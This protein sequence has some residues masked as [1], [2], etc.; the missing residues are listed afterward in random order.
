MRA[1]GSRAKR[2]GTGH[3]QLLT[4][5]AWALLLL[6]LWVW[7]RDLTDEVAGRLP[8][9]GD[10]AAVGRPPGAPAHAHAP[11]AA[12][13][14]VRPTHLT[15]G[16]LGVGADVIARGLAT[17]GAVT[18]PPPTAPDVVGWY[19]GGPPPGEKGAAVLLGRVAA[20][21]DRAVFNGLS[22][23]RPGNLVEV[24]RSDGS[25]AQFTVED[26]KLYDRTHFDARRAYGAHEPGRSE[27]RLI[28]T[29]GTTDP[30]TGDSP[31][32]VVVSAHLTGFEPARPV[33]G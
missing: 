22:S 17:N 3:G 33:A 14:T 2:L 1:D 28:A 9:T 21:S 7:G 4:G 5:V 23:I 8:T 13:S 32:N 29:G 12:S 20:P 11:V 6:G 16:A 19:A 25:T 24:Q 27:L 18:P 15:I 10:V 26:V 30:A 31:T